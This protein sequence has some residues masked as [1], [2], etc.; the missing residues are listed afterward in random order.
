MALW[1]FRP[2]SFL[3]SKLS[4]VKTRKEVEEKGTVAS[5]VC[6]LLKLKLERPCARRQSELGGRGGA[7]FA[8]SW[9]EG[10]Y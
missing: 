4:S 10:I 7:S 1:I 3:K 2:Q 8:F 6:F 5:L 9:K